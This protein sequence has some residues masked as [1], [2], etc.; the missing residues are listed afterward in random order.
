[1]TQE[2]V[3]LSPGQMVTLILSLRLYIFITLDG[4]DGNSFEV[5][6]PKLLEKNVL[7]QYFRHTR[8]Q[9]LVRQLNFYSFKVVRLFCCITFF[10]TT[11]P[12]L[13][14]KSAKKGRH[15]FM[16]IDISSKGS[17]SCCQS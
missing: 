10:K 12:H 17:R 7:P 6:D 8:F 13:Y 16:R 15:G 4:A 3:I 14:R 9:S 1:M 11:G 5:R 2:I